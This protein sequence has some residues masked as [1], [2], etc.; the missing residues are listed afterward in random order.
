MKPFSWRAFISLGLFVSFLMLIV[1]G[2][3]L[4]LAPPGRVANWTD[5]QL[6]GL[7]K[8][9]WQNQHTIFSFTFALLSIFHLFSINWKAFWSYIA[10]KTHAGLGKPFEIFSILLL[11]MFFGI[12]TFMQIQPFSAVIDFGKSLSESWEE[13]QSQPPIP[14]TERMT[15]KE[16]SD[17]FASGESPESLRGKLEKEGIRVTSLDQTLKNIGSENNTSAQ[18]VYELLD[19]APPSQ[20]PGRGNG[21]GRNRP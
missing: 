2:I 19:I 4:Y 18:K 12:G 11:A 14:H 10:A 6:L 17:Q 15:L 7:S 20:N 5:W 9:A 1:S 8:Q 21:Q 16:I 3:V 13:P